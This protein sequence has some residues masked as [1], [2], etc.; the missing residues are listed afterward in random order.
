MNTTP[1][2][3]LRVQVAQARP[4]VV[5]NSPA[6]LGRT[7][8]NDVVVNHPLVSRLHIAFEW[9]DGWSVVDRG[10]T[11]GFFVDGI[12]QQSIRIDRPVTIRVGDG[13]TGPL[14]ELIPQAP[15]Q[16]T[17]I[18]PAQSPPASNPLPAQQPP[19]GRRPQVNLPS[20]Q[21]PAPQRQQ[22]QPAPQ[23]QQPRP[24]QSQQAQPQ[25]GPRPGPAP[26]TAPQAAQQPPGGYRQAPPRFGAL[27]DAPHLAALHQNASAVYEVPGELRHRQT[28]SLKGVQTIGRTPDNDIVVSD[29][30]ASRHHARLTSTPQGML[31]EDLGS[32]NGTFVNGQRVMAHRL[33][34]S[35]VVTI[36]N[37]DFVLGDG[38]LV[39]G[40]PRAQVAG[41]L[42]VNGVGLTI[43]GKNLLNDVSFTAGLGSLTAI[44]G[45]SGAGKSTVS[46][47][48]AGLNNPTV[49]VV[50][51][52]GRGVHSEYEALRSRIGMVPQ[53]DVLHH[54]LTLRQAL[55]YAAEL[56]LPADLST[57]DRDEV[58]D[59][60]LSELQLTEHVNTRVDKLSGGQRKRA[61]VAMELLTGPSL[62]ILDEPTSGLDPALDLQVMKTLRRLA[63]AGRVV[64]VVTHSVAHLDLCDQI[65]LLA[66]GG[67][68]SFC[69]PPDQVHAEMGTTVWAEIFSY[70]AEQPDQAWNQYRQR[71]PHNAPPPR[72]APNGPQP[73]VP[74][75]G[76]FRQTSTVARRQVRL[77]WADTGYLVV[78]ALMP[79]VL[80]LLT[81]V[82]PGDKGFSRAEMLP[83]NNY[84]PPKD[85]GEALQILTVLVIGAAFMGT[86][87][88]VRDLVGERG[89]FERER[90]V[91]L[92]PGAYLSAKVIVFSLISLLQVGI[93]I[94]I[95]YT[96]RAMPKADEIVK[97][98]EEAPLIPPAVTLFIAV[99]TLA[100]VSVLVGLAI[101]A[102]VRSSEQTM[103]PLVIVVM[104]QLVLSGGLFAIGSAFVKPITW[105]FPTYWGYTN[106]AQ[107]VNI[108]WIADQVPQ[109]KVEEGSS[110]MYPLWEPSLGHALISYAALAAIALLLTLF[111]YSRL[112]L[113]KR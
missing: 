10:S 98:G 6:T 95:T 29:V 13:A 30:L 15:A 36:G 70:V 31:L 42:E 24:P 62:L 69:G 8:D 49:G 90:A 100:I 51:F 1:I 50:T 35:D 22:Q 64:L 63:D 61:S 59:G 91:G 104:V 58:I 20:Q 108:P 96:L 25:P 56:R 53:D 12:R 11:N 21:Q 80:G 52:E 28:I 93:M 32:V 23:R 83:T 19:S 109:V 99:A 76:L 85:P 2:T 17:M 48:V 110:M 37:S 87:L 112:R 16:P 55:R 3:P 40:R 111:I 27:P 94:A 97:T 39:R 74:K 92:R 71:H 75:M 7:P 45:P 81:L 66:P 41:G 46:K 57:R 44:I 68:T 5:R 103:P 73:T 106:A 72:V 9:A 67:K 38:K 60:V 86:A 89:I 101:S 78:L 77:V 102:A 4:Q 113:R 82:I 65:L 54:R 84:V 34:D 47:V 14:V 33:T 43:D 26:A 88:A 79:V 107:A 105:L 18:P